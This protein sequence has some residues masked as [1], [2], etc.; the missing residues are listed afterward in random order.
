MQKISLW[1]CCHANGTGRKLFFIGTKVLGN[2]WASGKEID[3]EN[4]R[5]RERCR[6]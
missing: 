5:E 2:K 1:P 3:T 6:L 4:E